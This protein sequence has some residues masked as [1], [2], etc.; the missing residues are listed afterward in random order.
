MSLSDNHRREL[1]RASAIDT[2]VITER[3]YQTLREVDRSR[4]A[5]LGISVRANDAFPGLLLP[6][7]RATGELISHQFKPLKPI[8]IKNKTIKLP[9]TASAIEPHRRSPAES[10]PNH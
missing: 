1:E 6:M 3:G 8:T 4:L 10:P 5:A 9:V 7:F 2:S